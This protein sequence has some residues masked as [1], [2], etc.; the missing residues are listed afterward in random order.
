MQI[1]RH[2]KGKTRKEEEEK[3]TEKQHMKLARK[4]QSEN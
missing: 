1:G 3:G 2:G 4:Q